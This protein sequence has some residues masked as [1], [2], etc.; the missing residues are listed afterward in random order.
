MLL[1]IT[2][3]ISTTQTDV[4]YLTNFAKKNIIRK[5]L[6]I[7]KLHFSHQTIKMT[8]EKISTLEAVKINLVFVVYSEIYR[9]L[10][11]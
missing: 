6:S 7:I 3:Y 8:L 9:E 2:A 10:T 1:F 5:K 11:S 4:F